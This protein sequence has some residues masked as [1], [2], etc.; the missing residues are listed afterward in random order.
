MKKAVVALSIA[1]AIAICYSAWISVEYCTYEPEI[2]TE[3]DTFR[4]H[5]V[6]TVTVVKDSIRYRTRWERTVDTIYVPRDTVLTRE[7]FCYE[8]SMATIVYSGVDP[9]I[10]SLSYRLQRDTVLIRED[11]YLVKPEKKWSF[12]LSV[13]PAIGWGAG[14]QGDRVIHTPFT[15]VAFCVGVNYK[16]K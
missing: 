16:I 12:G 2:R 5:S 14:L 7:Q 8:D 1:L 3:T 11:H 9:A 10:D 4:I 6:D 13:G 15:G